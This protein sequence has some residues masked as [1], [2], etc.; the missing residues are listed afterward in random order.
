MNTPSTLALFDFDGTISHKDSMV[1]FIQF[2]VG[3]RRYYSGLIKQSPMLLSYLLKR[4]SNSK[5]KQL[6]MAHYLSHLTVQQF[7]ALANDY[8]RNQLPAII[9]P[10][11]VEQIQ[12]HQQQQHRIV[13]ISASVE[14][15]LKPWTE[16]IRVDLIASHLDKA[17]PLINGRLHG[18]NCHGTE[19]V[20][21]LKKHLTLDDYNYIYAYGDSFGDTDMLA[22]ADEPHYKPFR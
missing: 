17:G 11:A 2:A 3:H 18:V 1:D 15:W 16:Q 9:R 13:I 12:W 10:K 14:D 5:A 20:T 21:R 8:A 7:E 4:T 19:K 6:F 22:L